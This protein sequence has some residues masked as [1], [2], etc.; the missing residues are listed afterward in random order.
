VTVE[1]NLH[2]QRENKHSLQVKG[3]QMIPHAAPIVVQR[4]VVVAEVARRL[5][6]LSMMLSVPPV[7]SPQQ[8][9]SCLAKIAPSIVMS[10]ISR[11]ALRA[12]RASIAAVVAAVAATVAQ[13]IA[14][15]AGNIPQRK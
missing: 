7:G 1:E 3:S 13:E 5:R 15:I 12:P 14:M 9:R 6:A 11:S 2:S 10:A 8:C 4:V